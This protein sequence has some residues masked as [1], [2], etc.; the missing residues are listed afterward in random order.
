[1][2]CTRIVSCFH[3]KS[4]ALIFEKSI[5]YS[6]DDFALFEYSYLCSQKLISAPVQTMLTRSLINLIRARHYLERPTRALRRF[7]QVYAHLE[8]DKQSLSAFT[9]MIFLWDV[10]FLERQ[11]HEQN[12]LYT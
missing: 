5:D 6:R 9:L 12:N 8:K 10:L 3:S 7:F 4:K 2:H 1:M 11:L